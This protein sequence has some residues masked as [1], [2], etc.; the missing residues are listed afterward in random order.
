M[1]KLLMM[2][3]ALCSACVLQAET[4]YFAM[5]SIWAP[6]QMPM[7]VSTRIDGIRL[8]AFYGDCARLNGLDVAA[9]ACRVRER[10]N[11]L[12]AAGV[13]TR[14]V[15]AAGA[16]IACAN[17]VENEF[18]GAQFGLWNHAQHG[19]GA[20]F[21]VV[22]TAAYFAGVQVGVFNWADDLD[23]LQ[24]GLVNVVPSQ[25]LSVLPILNVGW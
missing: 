10:F 4:D 2:G 21:G 6:G 1:K 19:Y 12:Q 14:A 7:S 13:F 17:F 3:A 18:Y 9:G 16:Q 23:G 20:Q 5:L 24:L 11:G 15:N 8:T 25:M 22:N